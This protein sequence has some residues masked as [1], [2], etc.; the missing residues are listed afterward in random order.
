M[1]LEYEFIFFISWVIKLFIFQQVSQY[2]FKV[3]TA[4]II[5][6]I[7]TGIDYWNYDI[8][9]WGEIFILP[10]I[11][12]VIKKK[13]HWNWLQYF[14]YTFFTLSVDDI[15]SRIASIYF[16]FLLRVSPED[17]LSYILAEGIPTFLT[18]PLY[19]VFLKLVQLD[20][21][22]LKLSISK[23][24][25]SGVIRLFNITLIIYYLSMYILSSIPSLVYEGWISTVL[26]DSYYRR[27]VLFSYLPIFIGFLL[28]INYSSRMSI[29]NEVQK[30]KD[31]QIESLG[32]Y[33]K[34]IEGL[35]QDIR[36]F[37]HDYTNL[38][39]SLKQAIKNRDIKGVEQIYDAVFLDSD[40]QFYKSKY[41]IANL[42]NIE[43]D[44]LKSIISVKLI[45]A[46]SKDIKTSIEVEN[47]IDIP[48]SLELINLLKIVSIF[49]DNAIEAAIQAKQPY[50]S[51]TY[52][53]DDGHKIMII[54]NSTRERKIDT[55]SIF[56]YGVSSKGDG[57]GIGLSNVRNI[58][59]SNQKISLMTS[60]DDYIFR[61]ELIFY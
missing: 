52:F 51:F 2:K 5:S 9:F 29:N 8:I 35:Y 31:D 23:G 36:R 22:N 3:T 50:I 43:N 41:D 34:H 24:W 13:Q 11:A 42:Y 39:S 58:V 46:Q 15:F 4:I 40:K 17:N 26:E 53:I 28:Y 33:S 10:V 25:L 12:Y 16:Q 54:E 6:I 47:R 20:I 57:R 45:E 55:K 59:S 14:F 18:L 37:R 7:L 32:K 44:A 21:D 1:T 49:L 30:M 48:D 27:L 38:L 60:S 19:F 61:H 56:H